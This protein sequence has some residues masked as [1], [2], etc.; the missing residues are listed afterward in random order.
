MKVNQDKF[1]LVVYQNNEGRYHVIIQSPVATFEERKQVS[2]RLI[3]AMARLGQS[4]CA[5]DYPTALIM[6][7]RVSI[8]S[9]WVIIGMV[10]LGYDNTACD[11]G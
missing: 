7:R 6:T 1:Q 8:S 9:S 2:V 3:Q 11:H 4:T 10:V 5:Y